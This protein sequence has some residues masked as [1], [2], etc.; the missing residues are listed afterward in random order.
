M[1]AAHV[2]DAVTFATKPVLASMM[3]DR[4]I[5]AG[6]PFFWVAADSVYVSVLKQLESIESLVI[7]CF[8]SD[9]QEQS[10]VDERKSRF[11]WTP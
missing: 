5:N 8:W 3:I 1:K 2:P 11:L 9:S 4:A 7:R 6:A 10:D